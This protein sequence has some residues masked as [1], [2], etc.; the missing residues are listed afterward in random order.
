[1]YE[2]DDFFKSILYKLKGCGDLEIA[3]S[4][5]DYHRLFLRIKYFGYRVIPA[6]SYAQHDQTRGF[7]HVEEIFKSLR[8]PII[9]AIVKTA[10]VKQADLNRADRESIAHYLQWDEQFIINN[11]R[12]L[13]VDD[14]MTTGATLRGCLA[15][16]KEKRPRKVEILV[17]SRVQNEAKR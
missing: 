1:L 17:L 4:F 3:P 13:L 6:P 5:L 12:I 2:Y 11:K 8:L 10:D 16:I 14:V 7:N 15:L 9:K